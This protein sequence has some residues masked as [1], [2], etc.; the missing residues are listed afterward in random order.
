MLIIIEIIAGIILYVMLNK[1]NEK[2]IETNNT[3]QNISEQNRTILENIELYKKLKEEVGYIENMKFKDTTV[4]A[5]IYADQQ[6]VNVKIYL[7]KIMI[8]KKMQLAIG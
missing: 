3:L 7:T 8:S 6:I 1:I 4:A 2:R 5:K